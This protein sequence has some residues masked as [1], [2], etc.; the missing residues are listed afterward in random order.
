MRLLQ[1]SLKVSAELLRG[2]K[3]LLQG[4]DEIDQV[5]CFYIAT[6]CTALVCLVLYSHHNSISDLVGQ[7]F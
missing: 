1:L 4:D 7:D 6:E 3:P 5:E 2:G